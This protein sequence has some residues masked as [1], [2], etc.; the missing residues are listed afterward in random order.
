MTPR[1]VVRMMIV[2]D[3]QI[4]GVILASLDVSFKIVLFYNTGHWSERCSK[5]AQFSP[6]K[7]N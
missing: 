7:L 3:A 4:C 6:H 1:R 5:L 2:S